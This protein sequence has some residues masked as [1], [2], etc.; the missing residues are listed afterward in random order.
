MLVLRRNLGDKISLTNLFDKDGKPIRVE[1]QLTDV[2]T[3]ESAKIGIEAD[4]SVKIMR[5]EIEGSEA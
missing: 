1:I 5:T 3:C 4:K 2:C